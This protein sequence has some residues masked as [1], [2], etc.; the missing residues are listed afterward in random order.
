MRSGARLPL[1]ALRTLKVLFAAAMLSTVIF[2]PFAGRFF[3][4]VDPLQ[5]SDVIMVLAGSRLDRW[6]EAL[7]LYKEGWAPAIV[8]SPGPLSPLETSMRARG[9][10]Y[11]REGD[12]AREALISLG[13]PEQAV[14]VMPDGVDNTAAE[15]AALRRLLIPG[16]VHRVIVVT[17]AY[18]VRRAGFAFRRGFQGS[19][20][21]IVMR[22][23]R[24]SAANPARWW[25]ARS[26]IRY[27]LSEL[28][29]YIAYRAGLD[30]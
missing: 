24:Y 17:S 7:D 20:V 10:R 11:P 4:S 28:P 1:A 8:L 23:S 6:L 5:R 15:A 12:L 30:E 22:G 16:S 18:H 14:T 9:M 26:D 29:K 25:T 21:E 19:G 13:V 27:I 3:S 2:L